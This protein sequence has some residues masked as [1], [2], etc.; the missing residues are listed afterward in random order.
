[1]CYFSYSFLHPLRLGMRTQT[2]IRRTQVHPPHQNQIQPDITTLEIHT[3]DI[4]TTSKTGNRY[5]CNFS[6]I[7]YNCSNRKQIHNWKQELHTTTIL[8]VGTLDKTGIR[9]ICLDRKQIQYGK[10]DFSTSKIREN[11]NLA[12]MLLREVGT[13]GQTGISYIISDRTQVQQPIQDLGTI[14]QTGIRYI[15]ENRKQIHL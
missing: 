3:Q 4:H 1:M 13:M 10:Q 11:K 2:Q 15:P 8:E 5:I 7:R 14:A 6:R 12:Q 9:Y